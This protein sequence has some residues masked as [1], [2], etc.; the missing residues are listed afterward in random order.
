MLMPRKF[1]LSLFA[2]VCVLGLAIQP[3]AADNPSRYQA[4]DR[5][6][7]M[8]E[9]DAAKAGTEAVVSIDH[10]RLAADT[11][12]T[13]PPA[14]VLLFADWKSTT[15]IMA[16]NPRAGLDLPFRVLAYEGSDG[17]AAAYT[18]ASFLKARHGLSGD[19]GLV[20]IDRA[21]AAATGSVMAGAARPLTG[22]GV[23][24]D[25]GILSISSRFGFAETID[26]LKAV[27]R[28]QYD[29]VWFGE[30]DFTARAAAIGVTLPP[31]TLLLFGGPKLGGVAM[32]AF[33]RLGLDAFCQKL[34]V[35][36][37][38]GGTEVLAAL[39]QLHYGKA[40]PPHLAFNERL[41][42]TFRQAVGAAQ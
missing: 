19:E 14:R 17:P 5:L 35:V 10:A 41:T 20:V 36:D 29:T 25:F 31:A 27:V 8:V 3:A 30:V 26:S 2:L 4:V 7:A 24:R 6:F 40:T 15:A 16:E 39:A 22:D 21:L 9:V 1:R 38:K 13:M 32:A 18:A 12:E 11:G 42:A 33:P 23:N 34:L 28:A 37:S